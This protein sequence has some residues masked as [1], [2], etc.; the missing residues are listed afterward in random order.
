MIENAPEIIENDD[1]GSNFT[2]DSEEEIYG[3]II[4]VILITY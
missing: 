1:A 4:K 2:S 3:G